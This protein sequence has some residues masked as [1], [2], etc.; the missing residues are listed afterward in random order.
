[1]PEFEFVNE[2]PKRT[3]ENYGYVDPERLKLA[4]AAKARPGE[5]LKVPTSFYS[6]LGRG[7]LDFASTIRSGKS[8]AFAPKGTFAAKA[9][10]GIAYIMYMGSKDAEV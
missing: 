10:N 3:S 9:R 4:N 1:M 6:H 5:W 2:I 7:P 8:P